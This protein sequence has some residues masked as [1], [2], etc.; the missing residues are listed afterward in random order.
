MKAIPVSSS[1]RSSSLALIFLSLKIRTAHVN[2]TITEPRRT[3]DTTE[4]IDSG[5][6]KDE[7]YAKSAI[8]MKS[9]I[10]GMD[11]FQVKA[12]VL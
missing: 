3:N 9:E 4:I 8:Q 12:V 10:S 11:H 2:D 5:L 7:K 6:F 1:T